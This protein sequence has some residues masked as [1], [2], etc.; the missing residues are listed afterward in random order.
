[1]RESALHWQQAISA[2]FVIVDA[3]TG[4]FLGGCG[5]IRLDAP[6]RVAEVG[7]WLRGAA[8]GRGVMTQ[9]VRLISGWVLRELGFVRLEL[10]ADVR[11]TPSHRVAERA[12]FRREGEVP[13]PE[14]CADRS[15][16]M[17]MFALTREEIDD[18]DDG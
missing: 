4:E 18:I 3:T 13:A 2:N 16:T 7:Y 14:R 9:A 10:Q 1:V 11:N 8:R 17:M 5:V 15:E 6:D 12:G